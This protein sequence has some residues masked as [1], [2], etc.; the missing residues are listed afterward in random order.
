MTVATAIVAIV[1]AAVA[2]VMGAMVARALAARRVSRAAAAL[3]PELPVVPT[4]SVDE[5][6]RRMERAVTRARD[7]S[8]AGREAAAHLQAAADA[9]PIGLVVA[10]TAEQVLLQNSVAERFSGARHADALVD[11]AVRLSIRSALQGQPTS[12][13]LELYGPPRRTVMVRSVPVTGRG[14]AVALIEDVTERSH[15]EA[16]RTDFVANISHELRTPV[17]A[18]ALLAETMVGEDDP[19]LLRRLA[20]KVGAEA[21]RVAR[22]IEDLLELSRLE[23]AGRPHLEVVEV[24]LLVAEAVE[25]VRLLASQREISAAVEEP[26]R[27]LT[28]VGDRRQLVSALANLVENGIKYSDPGSVVGVSAR[29]DGATVDLMVTD[30]GIGIP[31]RDQERIFERFYRVD[32]ARS[33][34]TGGTGLGL[35]IVRHVATNHGGTVSVTSAEG[36]GST[37]T[38]TIP[39]G[40]GP[41]AV[42]MPDAVTMPEAG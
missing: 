13:T 32:R 28:V 16:M 19:A 3:D 21:H 8:H 20:D 25:R 22:I 24:Q 30:H 29:T 36:Q 1:A 7:E 27:R 34:E 4:A 31:T 42:T 2:A 10:D 17:G 38:I 14:L 40:P 23:H 18:L 41:H 6:V 15:L 26:S 12:Q 35:A 11:E 37:F 39:A 33:R 5:A 9:L